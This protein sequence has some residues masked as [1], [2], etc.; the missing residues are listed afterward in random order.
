MEGLFRIIKWKQASEVFCDH[1]APV[2]LR[3][4]HYYMSVYFSFWINLQCCIELNVG[5]RKN[6]QNDN[7]HGLET[8]IL[9]WMF[10]VIGND[11]LETRI[12]TNVQL[13]QYKMKW[14]MLFEMV[15][16]C[17]QKIKNNFSMKDKSIARNYMG[18]DH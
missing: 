17:I 5:R 2:Q 6:W 13:I 8:C 11:A 18:E 7:L 15:W 10:G 3:G 9:R 12:R 1:W 16:A 4:Y 14:M